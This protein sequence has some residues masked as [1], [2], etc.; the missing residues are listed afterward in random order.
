MPLGTSGE[1][2]RVQVNDAG[3]G[4]V[5]A[6]RGNRAVAR[7]EQSLGSSDRGPAGGP[8]SSG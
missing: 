2:V 6:G 7:A 4:L 3:E 8:A 5:R 1:L